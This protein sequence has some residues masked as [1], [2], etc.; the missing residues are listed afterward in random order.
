[1]AYERVD[2]AAAGVR[3]TGWTG[4][5]IK[6]SF[7]EAVRSARLIVTEINPGEDWHFPPFTPVAIYATGTLMLSGF[8]L[9]Y[10]PSFS[11]SAHEVVLTI[12]TDSYNYVDCSCESETGFFENKT[13]AQIA[14]ALD[15]YGVGISVAAQAA[16][17]AAE[18]VPWFQIRLGST[19]WAEIMRLLPQ[20]GLTMRGLAS[21]G[22][23]IA[24]ESEARHAG[25]LIE[26]QNT[27]LTATGLLTGREV[28][29]DYSAIG[30]GDETDEA[31][32]FEPEGTAFDARIP[33][34]RFKQ[35]IVEQAADRKTLQQRAEWE[36]A[37]AASFSARVTIVTRGWRDAAGSLWEPGQRVYVESPRLKIWRDMLIEEAL[38]SQ[39]RDS[40]TITTLTL[41]AAGTGGGST[42]DAGHGDPFFFF[43]P[44]P[45]RR[46]NRGEE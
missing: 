30:Q 26:G 18:I 4:V 13:I 38:F 22:A 7:P 39:D 19:P 32:D 41:T 28:Y 21:G 10:Q 1:M 24:R 29:S 42:P 33:M 15:T 14:Q 46:P 44:T 20:R 43:R 9:D 27:I 2:L 5:Q 25:G 6:A 3:Y 37:R 11:E 34:H 12:V 35:V 16:A 31:D 17:A 40:G 23:E 8:V 36:K 45:T